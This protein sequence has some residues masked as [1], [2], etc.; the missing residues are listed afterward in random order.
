GGEDLRVTFVV[1]R[2]SQ[3]GPDI[4][5]TKLRKCHEHRLLGLACSEIGQDVA[6]RDPGSLDTGLSR[7][8]ARL[9]GDA[10]APV[11]RA[12]PWIQPST[13]MTKRRGGCPPRRFL[14]ASI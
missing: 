6:D 3:G 9:D 10:F 12:P 14:L 1:G 4:L 13:S 11:H 8:L 2:I 7:A 5:A